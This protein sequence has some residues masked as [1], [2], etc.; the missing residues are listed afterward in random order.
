MGSAQYMTENCKHNQHK[1]LISCVYYI[2]RYNSSFDNI[3]KV[4]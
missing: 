3:I 4:S 2:E 1:I